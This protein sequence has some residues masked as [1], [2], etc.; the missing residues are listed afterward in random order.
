MRPVCVRA[1]VRACCVM[2]VIRTSAMKR[3][4]EVEVTHTLRCLHA[5]VWL[6]CSR[7]SIVYNK[8][9]AGR[10]KTAGRR[11]SSAYALCSH[12]M[13]SAH[14]AYGLGA[15]LMVCN[16]LTD[17]VQTTPATAKCEHK[18]RDNLCWH[19]PSFA[20]CAMCTCCRMFC[21]AWHIR[22]WIKCWI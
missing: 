6:L 20:R 21:V 22:D 15:P 13:Q 3:I 17:C 12:N 9:A 18:K 1:F 4:F 16:T 11:C 5:Y 10:H 14:N 7:N 2:Y 19:I 8:Q